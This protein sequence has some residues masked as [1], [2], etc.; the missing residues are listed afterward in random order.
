MQSEKKYFLFFS[1]K[2]LKGM[3][4]KITYSANQKKRDVNKEAKK[5]TLGHKIQC[6]IIPPLAD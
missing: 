1:L 4:K 6:K 2:R 5:G 3:Q